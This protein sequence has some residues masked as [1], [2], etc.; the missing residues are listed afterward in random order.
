MPNALEAMRELA[1]LGGNPS[2]PHGVGRAARRCLE[3][4]GDALREF[5]NAPRAEVLWAGGGHEAFALALLGLA[6]A[7]RA[8][9]CLEICVPS[10]PSAAA[11]ACLGLLVAE[12]FR[13]STQVDLLHAGTAVLLLEAVNACGQIAPLS[14]WCA[15]AQ[16]AAVPVHLDIPAGL[17]E[18]SCDFTAL[19]LDACTLCGHKLGGPAGVGAILLRKGLNLPPLWYGGGQ[20]RGMRPGTEAS[21]LIVG[22]G[23]AVASLGKRVNPQWG[24]WSLSLQEHARGLRGAWVPQGLG[25]S[26]PSVARVGV[27]GLSGAALAH[28]YNQNGVMVASVGCGEQEA[29]VA[30]LSLGWNSTRRDVDSAKAALETI[31]DQRAKR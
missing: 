6:R 5:L 27:H 1:F 15:A 26:L 11:Q 31:M 3:T 17:G 29:G 19:G 30:R 4:A 22:M 28:A 20:Q 24:A 23:H 13:V 2:S 18:F 7:R 9:G 12:G 21:P 16:L 25:N 8:Q 14:A 10:P